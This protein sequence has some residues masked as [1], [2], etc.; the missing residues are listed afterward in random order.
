MDPLAQVLLNRETSGQRP[1]VADA[2]AEMPNTATKVPPAWQRYVTAQ[3]MQRA[4]A[5]GWE[6]NPMLIRVSDGKL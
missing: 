2:P 4:Y 5:N 3:K 6:P 1:Y